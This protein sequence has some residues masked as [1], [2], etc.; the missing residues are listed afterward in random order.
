[1]IVIAVVTLHMIVSDMVSMILPVFI[2]MMVTTLRRVIIC[3][4]IR[5]YHAQKD[6]GSYSLCS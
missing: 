6:R 3:D 4:V 5:M 1:M 2:H